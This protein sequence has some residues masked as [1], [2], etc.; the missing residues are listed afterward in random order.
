[1]NVDKIGV[2]EPTGCEAATTD[3]LVQEMCRRRV[4]YTIMTDAPANRPLPRDL[5]ATSIC[6]TSLDVA[7]MHHKVLGDWIQSKMDIA[8]VEKP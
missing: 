8:Q 3:Q 6:I 2:I 7:R 4:Q 1:M 5:V